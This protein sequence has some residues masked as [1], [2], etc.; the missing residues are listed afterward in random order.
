MSQD[1]WF[2]AGTHVRT[3]S[4]LPGEDPAAH[5]GE[6]SPERETDIRSLTSKGRYDR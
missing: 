1:P 6:I 5:G 2:P 4:F 3:C